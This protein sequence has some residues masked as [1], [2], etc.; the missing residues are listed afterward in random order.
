LAALLH[1][2]RAGRRLP[3]ATNPALTGCDWIVLGSATEISPG[4][5]Q[6]TDSQAA[7]NPRRFYRMCSP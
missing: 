3:A 5:F 7:S 4:Q 2:L 1:Y 6:F